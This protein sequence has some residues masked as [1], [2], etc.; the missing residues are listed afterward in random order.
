[1][2]S[3]GVIKKLSTILVLVAVVTLLGSKVYGEAPVLKIPVIKGTVTSVDLDRN[4]LLIQ[5]SEILGS[6]PLY[7][8]SETS[9]FMGHEGF[10]FDK[11]NRNGIAISAE[12]DFADISD[13]DVGC[14]V[15]CS[16]TYAKGGKLIADNIVI[17]KPAALAPSM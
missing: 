1:M 11:C 8:W 15:Y 5:G 4:C 9:V 13:L 7:M 16:Y 14:E 2:K 6:D 10:D 12:L 17:T 3:Y